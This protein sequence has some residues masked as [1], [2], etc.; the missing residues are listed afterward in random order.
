[1]KKILAIA[2]FATI[3]AVG[4]AKKEAAVD[5]R[6]VEVKS[7]TDHLVVNIERSVMNSSDQSVDE[8]CAEF[9]RHIE[10]FITD[11]QNKVK[12]QAD[13]YF[14]T[15]AQE[16]RDVPG[17]YKLDFTVRDEVFR[18]DA[19]YIS[20]CLSIY[21]FIG[22]ANGET[23]QFAF[24]YDVRSRKFLKNDEVLDY[25]AKEKLNG[26]LKQHFDNSGDCF[27][28]EPTVD[29]ASAVNFSSTS[30]IFTYAQYVLGPRSCGS[31]RIEIPLKDIRDAVLLK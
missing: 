21:T 10:K 23:E 27:T 20:L 19:R 24:N 1:M 30:V 31:A 12:S 6:G 16:G 14:E 25:A 5:V 4:C 29:L 11:Q 22:G 7:Q 8:S 9:N 13:T 28:E 17:D 18:A 2:A 26:A 3:L 15:A